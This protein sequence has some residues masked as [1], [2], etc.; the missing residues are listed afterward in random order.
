MTALQVKT[1]LLLAGLQLLM[2]SVGTMAYLDPKLPL[3][4]YTF[5]IVK[6]V[7]VFK[8]NVRIYPTLYIHLMELLLYILLQFCSTFP[9]FYIS[10]NSVGLQTFTS[11]AM[12]SAFSCK[13]KNVTFHSLYFLYQLS[14][15]SLFCIIPWCASA[16]LAY[17]PYSERK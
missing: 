5:L 13:V 1:V 4:L 14:P 9:V 10:W 17:F 11:T 3:K 2:L 7:I 8:I 15:V 16:S 6:I 12:S